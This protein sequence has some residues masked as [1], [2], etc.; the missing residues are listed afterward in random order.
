MTDVLSLKAAVRRLVKACG[1]QEACALMPGMPKNKRPQAFSDYGNPRKPD[2]LP[3]R[4]LP[5]MEADCGQPIVSDVLAAVTGHKLV[6]LP[7]I[8]SQ[9]NA[10]GRITFEALK[11]TSEVFARLGASL[12]DG[13]ISSAEGAMLDSEIDEA[14][15]K[16]LAL[17]AQIDIEAGKDE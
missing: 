8:A 3:L 4:L 7:L 5:I 1:G 12:E 11:E 13:S 16:L 17:R 10:L 6:P 15:V 14:I 9:R 2:M